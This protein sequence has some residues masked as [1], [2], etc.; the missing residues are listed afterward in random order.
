[1]APAVV[2]TDGNP[3]YAHRRAWLAEYFD[4]TA[5]KA[6]A[7]LTSDAPVSGIRRTV[8]E[9]RERMASTL[10]GWLPAD[11]SGKRV[12]D[13]GC[14]PGVLA[15]ALA[16]RGAHVVGVDL[17]G[18]LLEVAQAR[19][20]Q[21]TLRGSV[22]LHTGDM[23]DPA[24]GS[25]DYVVAMDSLIHY[26]LPDMLG[27]ISQFAARTRSGI[28]GTFAPRTPLL[29]VMHAAGRMFPRRDRAPSIEPVS[30]AAFR[31]GFGTH[32]ALAEWQV[33]R[34]SRVSTGFYTSQAM[35]LRRTSA[36]SAPRRRAAE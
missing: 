16:Q 13:A 4:R 34:M 23:L 32:P 2:P 22:E 15:I 31:T 27:A 30:E 24:L 11:L 1:M 12:L 26:E 21:E 36:S 35:E 9:G 7:T 6:W 20:D 17:A 25:F 3:S 19:I 8:R 33:G 29:S 10:L 28:V 14:G 5:S 18:S